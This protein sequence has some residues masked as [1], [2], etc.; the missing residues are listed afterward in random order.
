MQSKLQFHKHYP[1]FSGN[2]DYEE[3]VTLREVEDP[4]EGYEIIFE[5][6]DLLSKIDKF[7]KNVFM[8]LRDY[9]N[10][11]GRIAAFVPL[12]EE[13]FGI[14]QFIISM[15]T[16]MHNIIGSVEVLGPLRDSFKHHH[17]QLAQFYEDCRG[18]HYLNSLITIPKL[19]S[20]PIDFLA[21]GA[22]TQKP[23]NQKSNDEE[24]V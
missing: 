16:A 18:L 9:G 14:Y 21:R 2:F 15:M 17:Y 10:N 11:E 1:H 24:E 4:N 7:Q 3:Y 12:V 13:S 19:S 6:L 23:K 22:P 8:N 20:E 5:L